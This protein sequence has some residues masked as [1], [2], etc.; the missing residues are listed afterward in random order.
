MAEALERVAFRDAFREAF[1]ASRVPLSFLFIAS[2]LV[3]VYGQYKKAEAAKVADVQTISCANTIQRW[4]EEYRVMYGYY[5]TQEQLVVQ[6][7]LLGSMGEPYRA[8][9]AN[10]AG[11]KPKP[12]SVALRLSRNGIY[13]IYAIGSRRDTLAT[14]THDTWV[15]D[16]P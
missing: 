8:K 5:P 13:T 4:S 15:A 7:A 6:P 14:L 1:K 12:Y 3:L 11:S 16:K 9:L 2:M 10:G